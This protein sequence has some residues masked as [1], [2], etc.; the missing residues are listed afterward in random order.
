ME[1]VALTICQIYIV[2]YQRDQGHGLMY[3]GLDGRV[4]IPIEK[5]TVFKATRKFSTLLLDWVRTNTCL[6]E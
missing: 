4:G 5:A 3:R 6:Y 2:P 1:L